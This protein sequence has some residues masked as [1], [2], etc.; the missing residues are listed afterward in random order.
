MTTRPR[1]DARAQAGAPATSLPSLRSL[2]LRPNRALSGPSTAGRMDA[3][4]HA[5]ASVSRHAEHFAP[6]LEVVTSFRS[7]QDT[8]SAS[9]RSRRGREQAASGDWHWGGRRRL[10]GRCQRASAF[11]HRAAL[12]TLTIEFRV[13]ARSH[14]VLTVILRGR[15]R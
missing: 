9:C 4:S 6:A 7:R 10:E 1:A 5:G 15:Q 14:P 13:Q 12:A 11:I 8:W 2:R 3:Y